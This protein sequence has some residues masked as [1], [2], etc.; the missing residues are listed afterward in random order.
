MASAPDDPVLA[1]QRERDR[2]DAL[3]EANDAWRALRQLEAREAEGRP[4]STVDGGELRSGIQTALERDR[5]FL[6][7]RKISEA[8]TLLDSPV[9]PEQAPVATAPVDTAS[10]DR[11][12]RPATPAMTA[13]SAV[14]PGRAAAPVAAPVA[15]GDDLTQIHSID[16]ALS[17][18]LAALGVTR[19]DDIAVWTRSDV[20]RIATAL[21][22]GRAISRGNWIEQAA[23]KV[24]ARAAAKAPESETAAKRIEVP[25]ERMPEAPAA[26]P[27]QVAG[28]PAARNDTYRHLIADAAR[29]IFD[30]IRPAE[31]APSSLA[32][33]RSTEAIL[34]CEAPEPSPEPSRAPLSTP[35]TAPPAAAGIAPK[36]NGGDDLERIA[37]LEAANANVLRTLGVGDFK[38]IARLSADDVEV[39]RSEIGATA[40]SGM[41]QW[42]EQAA[43]L[44]AGGTSHHERSRRLVEPLG[45][46]TAPDAAAIAPDRE[47]SA[48]LRANATPAERPH[49]QAAPHLTVVIS[50]PEPLSAP[51]PETVPEKVPETVPDSLP[52]PVAVLAPATVPEPAVASTAA[53]ETASRPT[54]EPQPIPSAPQQPVPPPVAPPPIEISVLA[55]APLAV[56]PDPAA[57]VAALARSDGTGLDAPDL[58]ATGI[59]GGDYDLPEIAYVEADVEIVPAKPPAVATTVAA[60]PDRTTP[61]PSALPSAGRSSA[62]RSIDGAG[63]SLNA[64]LRRT[65]AVEDID[66]RDY[67]AY[68][69][70]VEE[71]SVEIVIRPATG[72]AQ[73]SASGDAAADRTPPVGAAEAARSA[74]AGAAASATRPGDMSDDTSAEEARTVRRFLSALQRPPR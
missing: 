3:L 59:D 17:D 12:Q 54:V 18:R 34:S 49:R 20:E 13:S 35:H 29:R 1:L 24:A 52:D 26:H 15:T 74:G 50:Q 43:L 30:R 21:G 37:G 61:R 51:E 9:A 44:A 2:L 71:A 62:G 70:E 67:A 8:I 19:F 73:A 45:L 11:G 6:A 72:A 46:A 57:A 7:R 38:S 31:P 42:I 33:A 39:V 4:V 25:R 53:A 69:G 64:R 63:T 48:W 41:G 60:A 36:Q 32:A 56:P 14:A 66:A 47:M 68:R 65:G 23:A 5:V 58:D 16:R 27:A 40:R 10:L 55:A 22:L 28:P